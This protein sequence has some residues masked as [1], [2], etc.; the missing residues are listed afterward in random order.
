MLEEQLELSREN[1]AILK[2]IR[3]VQKNSQIFRIVY[4]FIII[5]ISVGAF[6][7]IQPY[8][9]SLVGS[10]PDFTHIQELFKQMQDSDF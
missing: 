5:G 10:L 6:Y 3:R 4:W 1:N 2:K 7:F 9:E 8:L